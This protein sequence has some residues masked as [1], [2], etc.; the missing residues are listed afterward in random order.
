M[1][2]ESVILF[3]SEFSELSNLCKTEFLKHK[4]PVVIIPLDSPKI[5]SAAIERGIKRV[6][7]LSVKHKNG[8]ISFYVGKDKIL[9]WLSFVI[10]S[11]NVREPVTQ[12]FHNHESA[13]EGFYSHPSK[14]HDNDS[15]RKKKSKKSKKPKPVDTDTVEFLNI[16]SVDDDQE[17][18]QPQSKEGSL[19]LSTMSRPNNANQKLAAEAKRLMAEASNKLGSA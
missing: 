18:T 2:V 8:K 13:R 9:D 12:H 5:R 10:N 4:A 17:L 19:G 11:R 6:P 14:H 15:P 1:E 3:T 7:T 16:E